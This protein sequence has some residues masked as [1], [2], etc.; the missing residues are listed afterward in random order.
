MLRKLVQ[1]VRF[2]RA[3][4]R[5][6]QDPNQL[7]VVFELGRRALVGSTLPP[8]LA[9]PE[10]VAYV[11]SPDAPPPLHVDIDHLRGLAPGTL[12]RS[13]ADWIAAQNFTP[14]ELMKYDRPPKNVDNEVERYRAHLQSTHDLWHVLTGFGTHLEGEIGLQAFYLAQLN[15]PLSLVTIAAASL[16]V[17]REHRNAADLMESITCGWRMGKT[18]R[19]LF[20][21]DWA[22]LWST[23]LTEVRARFGLTPVDEVSAHASAPAHAA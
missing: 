13:F 15:T 8:E 23:P 1:S 10:V 2:F 20:G 11:R 6:V 5:L 19:A 22:S 17:L 4:N 21:V 7:E 9:R 18:T 12:G 3:F 16:N 14:N